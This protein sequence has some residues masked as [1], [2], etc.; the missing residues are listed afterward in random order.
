MSA[1]E[2][3]L[4]LVSEAGVTHVGYVLVIYSFAF[5]LFLLTNI[6]LY[7]YSSNSPPEVPA[8]D[9][10]QIPRLPRIPRMNGHQPTDSRQIRD[11]EE[12]EL[13]GLMSDDDG[14]ESPS[15]LGRNNHATVE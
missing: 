9:A 15:T 7:V 6:L 1:T 13:E 14:I 12:F 2:E 3:Q 8:K 11:A 4:K 5:L 10:E